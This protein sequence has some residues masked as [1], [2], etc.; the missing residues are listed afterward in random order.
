MTD[1]VDIGAARIRLIV[2]STDMQQALQQGK[3]YVAGFGSA[4]QDAYNRT[5]KGTRRA[6]D[7]LLDYVSALGSADTTMTRLVKNATKMGV[8]L[9][10][11]DP[12]IAKWQEYQDTLEATA[13]AQAGYSALVQQS[14]ADELAAR[15]KANAAAA[16]T[17]KNLQGAHAANAQQSINALVAPGLATEGN[18]NIK[19][20]EDAMA[21]FL[22]LIQQQEAE[23]QAVN[24]ALQ[25]QLALIETIGEARAL[26]NAQNSQQDFNKILGIPQQE[27][28]LALIQRRK[29]AEAAFLPVLEEE[30]KLEQENTALVQKQQ[31][32]L[33]ELEQLAATAGKSGSALQELRAQQLGIS[34]Q[35]APLIKAVA[36]ANAKISDGT[37]SAKQYAFALRGL[38]AQFTDIVVSLQGGQAPLTVLLQQGGQIKDMFGGVGAA[39]KVVG[40]ELLGIVTNPFIILG[41]AIAGVAVS[42]YEASQRITDLAI[43]TAKGNQVAGQATSLNALINS[44]SAVGNNTSGSNAVAAV[45]NLAAAGKLS[46]QSFDQAA[47]ATARWATVTGQ[48]VDDVAGKF[49][50]L[51]SDPLQAVYNGTLKVTDA[52]YQ[53]LVS[54]QRV[55]DT[56]D[57]V[58][59]AVSLYQ[60][61]I[62]DNTDSVLKNLSDGEKGWI[63]LKVA[64]SDAVHELGEW[65]RTSAGLVFNGV[66]GFGKGN[67][68]GDFTQAGEFQVPGEDAVATPDAAQHTMSGFGG[69]G[70]DPAAG[71]AAAKLT[72]LQAAANDKLQKSYDELGTKQEK[73]KTELAL[74]IGTIRNATAAQRE[75]DNITTNADGSF[76]GAGYQKLVNGLRLKIFGQNEGGD[77]TKP[78]LE[79]QKAAL[80]SLKVVSDAQAVLYTDGTTD[81]ETYYGIQIGLA[82]AD[83]VIQLEAI[84][85]EIAAL[86]G[87]ANQENKIQ[88]LKVERDTVNQTTQAN[89]IKLTQQETV[90]ITARNNAI[91]NYVQGLADANIQLSRQGGQAVI[92]TALGSR[93][94]ALSNAK[95]NAV[96]AEQLQERAAQQ[97]V[98]QLPAGTSAD[99]HAAAQVEATKKITAAQEALSTQLLIIQGNYDSLTDAQS[100]FFNG[101]QKAW[102][103][104]SDNVANQAAFA[105]KAVTTFLD[106]IADAFATAAT[107]G[108]LSFSSLFTSLETMVVQAGIKIAEQKALS[109]ILNYGGNGG[110]GDSVVGGSGFGG[111][112]IALG[113]L[114]FS[115]KGNAFGSSAGLGAYRNQVVSKPTYFPFEKGG[116]PNVGLMGE[117]P[118]SPGEAI[119]PLTR[120][121]NGDLGVKVSGNGNGPVR[122]NNI[123]Q[124][125]IVPGAQTRRT[126]DQMAQASASAATRAIRRN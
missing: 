15:A 116:V 124:V 118:G 1:T 81:A 45:E 16:T 97:A 93:E 115:A 68:G 47:Q 121:A 40:K 50:E 94:S 5:E 48:S 107:K 4:A 32:F 33:A 14:V 10:A 111:L 22:P 69:V 72:T 26:Q 85:K 125:F 42:A 49:S 91:Q 95:S 90:A 79:W 39:I 119:M 105:N 98:D 113:S 41:A 67:P 56:V 9:A 84:D 21:A 103:D 66:K 30:A 87:R 88:A 31:A 70:T 76:G 64:I 77:P 18:S 101:A 122:N 65:A 58:K 34:E 53:Q 109:S 59:L 43:A 100:K 99:D 46:G 62:N 108:K 78:I 24:D 106:G 12:A 96:Y 61:Q 28:A 38:P 74:L 11:I 73:Y 102:Q 63:D 89:I 29:D 52:Q 123:N 55:G 60:A 25:E 7:A 126:Q 13:K 3:S 104:W 37:I 17:L 80:D 120:T 36:D 54:L 51:A 92:G 82:R 6:I 75:Q 57:E 2:D 19:A 83:Q 86:Q 71:D 8:E 110:G 23:E 35:A 112:G 114:L 44:I 27:E 20:Q 117:K